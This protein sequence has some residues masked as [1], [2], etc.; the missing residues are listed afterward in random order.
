[1][2]ILRTSIVFAAVASAALRAQAATYQLQDSYIGEAF[3][4]NFNWETFSDPSGGFVNYVDQATAIDNNLTYSAP[5]PLKLHMPI[6]KEADMLFFTADA[7]K[8]V[9]R[10]DDKKVVP[11]GSRGRDSIRITSH[12][13]YS[14]SAIVLDL[15]HM[16]GGCGQ[17][18]SFWT[19]DTSQAWP[20]GGEIDILEVSLEIGG[21]V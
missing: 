2:P 12:K 21:S 1:M 16:P 19:I 20:N 10:G 13:Q 7:T 9:I 14:S 4:D 15:V 6:P 17:W 11:S 8:F 5:L 18:P 3:L